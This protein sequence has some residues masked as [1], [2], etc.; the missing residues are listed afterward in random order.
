MPRRR[1]ADGVGMGKV[2]WARYTADG[3]QKKAAVLEARHGALLRRPPRATVRAWL[4]ARDH[5]PL[6]K[7]DLRS[8]GTPGMP[9]GLH[10]KTIR[11]PSLFCDSALLSQPN[12]FGLQRGAWGVDC[13]LPQAYNVRH[14]AQRG[15]S[16]DMGH[17]GLP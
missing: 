16:M 10:E 8:R 4:S 1:A 14:G 2:G 6:Q 9:V 7:G 13:A 15:R 17:N 5:D 12:T 3:G 11:I